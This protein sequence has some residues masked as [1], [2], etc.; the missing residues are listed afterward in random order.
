M[1]PLEPLLRSDGSLRRESHLKQAEAASKRRAT[2][3][4]GAN[5]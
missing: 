5:V 4:S 2:V 3:A 1:D